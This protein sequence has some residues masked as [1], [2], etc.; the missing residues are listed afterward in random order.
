MRGDDDD[1]DNDDDVDDNVDDNDVDVHL[2]EVVVGVGGEGVPARVQPKRGAAWY[3]EVKSHIG[4]LLRKSQITSRYISWKC[5]LCGR[6][7]C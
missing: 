2:H 7:G 5:S 1:D 6:I 4:G 3:R